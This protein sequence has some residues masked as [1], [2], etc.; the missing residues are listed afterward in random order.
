MKTP[1]HN[2][3]SRSAGFTIVEIVVAMGVLL[4]GMSAILGLLTFGATMTRA[5]AMRGSA[6][7]SV[8]AVVADLEETLFPIT[9]DP[10]TGD[11]SVG[12]PATVTSVA[13][14]GYPGLTYT[15]KAVPD[16]SELS[17]RDGPL[18]YLVTVEMHWTAGGRA[19]SKSFQTLLLRQVPFGERLRRELI[20]R[21]FDAPPVAGPA[22]ATTSQKP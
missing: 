9:R 13:V 2:K 19:R 6:S 5:A 1:R 20:E 8:E 17:A 4:L 12:E 22:P 10:Q 7:T 15:A 18:R 16:P 3:S 21:R 14:P 11:W